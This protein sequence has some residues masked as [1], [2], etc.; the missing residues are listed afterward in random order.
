MGESA[1]QKK[2][3]YDL[4]ASF[5]LLIAKSSKNSIYLHV[6]QTIYSLFFEMSRLYAEKV[7]NP[8]EAELRVQRH[9]DIFRAIEKRDPDKAKKLM[10]DHFRM[11]EQL[12]RNN[13]KLNESKTKD[14][15]N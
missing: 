7:F 5:H 2:P 14:I 4:D 15:K 13:P 1:K 11:A 9:A 12:F 10:Q 3:F 6:A 8:D